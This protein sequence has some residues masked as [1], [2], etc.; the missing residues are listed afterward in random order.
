MMPLPPPWY[1]YV[2]IAPGAEGL[3]HFKIGVTCEPMRRPLNVQTGCPF[4]ITEVLFLDMGIESIA[5]KAEAALHV[6][7]GDHRTSG[8]WF[9]FDTGNPE[10]KESFA[11]ASREVCSFY[12]GPDW[13]WVRVTMA[14]IRDARLVENAVRAEARRQLRAQRKRQWLRDLARTRSR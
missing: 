2:M 6:Q 12:A 4:K 1:L 8:E 7:L 13:K 3:A 10:H 14:Q 11:A 5:R 9:A